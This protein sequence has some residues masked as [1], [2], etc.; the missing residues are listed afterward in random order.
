MK[1]FFRLA[2][3]A[4]FVPGLGCAVAG[5]AD[6]AQLGSQEQ[7]LLV[8]LT[9]TTFNSNILKNGCYD[10]S[11]PERLKWD[12]TATSNTDDGSHLSV[13][14]KRQTGSN[15]TQ[16]GTPDGSCT[17]DSLDDEC[18]AFVKGVTKNLT[19]SSS[20]RRGANVI[21]AGSANQGDA[22][23]TFSDEFTY[24]GHTGIFMRYT[25]NSA[26]ARDGF[27]MADQNWGDGLSST[28]W[29]TK[30][31]FGVEMSGNA[32]ANHYYFVQVSN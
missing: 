4:A 14:C 13:G 26:S 12:C 23:A 1:T 2:C 6:D 5:D 17:W 11:S 22:I 28:S 30:H 29:V 8:R 25:F 31:R 7:A 20:W 18:V 3:L 24:S 21:E 19:P 27:M 32:D 9:A 15:D 10:S 16:V